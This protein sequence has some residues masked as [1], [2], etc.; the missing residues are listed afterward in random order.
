MFKYAHGFDGMERFC[1]LSEFGDET[2]MEQLAIQLKRQMGIRPFVLAALL[3][4]KV[5]SR[6]ID[7]LLTLFEGVG[8]EI[9][10]DGGVRMVAPPDYL[11]TFD[12]NLYMNG[13][14]LKNLPR[15][16]VNG[17]VTLTDSM[18]ESL[19]FG[20]RI[21]GSLDLENTN[22]VFLPQ[23]LQVGDELNIY[24]TKI[25]IIPDTVDIGGIIYVRDGQL[26]AVPLGMYDQIRPIEMC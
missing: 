12:G 18:L 22:L 7:Q 1:R 4:M 17:D 5:D 24:G 9:D 16:H 23:D 10:E 11:G 6:K 3:E 15:L 8:F 21:S 2:A 26:D 14:R 25:N 13:A 19:S 20:T